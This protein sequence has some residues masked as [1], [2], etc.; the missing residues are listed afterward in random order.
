MSDDDLIPFRLAAETYP[1]PAAWKPRVAT[2]YRWR[3]DGVRGHKLK[4]VRIAGRSFVSVRAIKEF[5]AAV[6]AEYQSPSGTPLAEVAALAGA[7]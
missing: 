5:L 7:R 3:R 6:D 2:L 4:V 1:F